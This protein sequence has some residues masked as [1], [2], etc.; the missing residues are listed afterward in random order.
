MINAIERDKGGIAVLWCP[1]LGLR[2]WLVGE[3]ESVAAA[4]AKPIR[5]EDVE[6]ALTEPSRLVLLV[7]HNERDVVLDLDARRDQLLEPQ[8][9]Q[10]IVLFLIRG[11]DGQRALAGEAMSLA[12][13]IGGSDADPEALAQV[14]PK[15]EREAF[16]RDLGT[17]PEAWL[18]G[19]RSGSLPHTS[20]N[21][22]TAYRAMLLEV[23]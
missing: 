2:D 22:R 23:P 10:P 21:F 14:D 17:T 6:A 13:W 12:S 4:D 15:V 11:G 20:E 7:P 16:Q 9:S 1:D 5:K 19:W 18:E 8:R 3:V